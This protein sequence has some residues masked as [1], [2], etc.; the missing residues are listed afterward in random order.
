[1]SMTD[2]KAVLRLKQDRYEEK[3]SNDEN[4]KS[5]GDVP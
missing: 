4:R 1:M 5:M 3:I 2:M